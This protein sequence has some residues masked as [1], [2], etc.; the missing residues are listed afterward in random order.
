LKS[1]DDEKKIGPV[2]VL[3]N[4]AGI[5]QTQALKRIPDDGISDIIDTNLMATIWASK[6]AQIRS[7][8]TV[9]ILLHIDVS[10]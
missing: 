6:H 7:H 8:G 2:D 5:T 4:C 3:V 1:F 9:I 10:R